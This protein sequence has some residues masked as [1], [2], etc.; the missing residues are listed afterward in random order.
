M[1]QKVN[2]VAMRLGITQE[3]KSKWF[4]NSR[5]Y[6]KYLNA[7]LRVRDFLLKKLKNASVSHIHI[8]RPARNAKVSI[9]SA[10][11]GVI[12]GKKGGEVE[13]LRDQVSK[14]MGVPVHL[15]IEEIRKPELNAKLVAEGIAQQL[16]RRI[17]FRRAM[18]RAVQSTLR[19]GALGIKVNVGGRLG[20]AEIARSE[21]YREGR[22]PLHTFRAD[23][24]YGT[25]RANTTY[26]V[27]GVKVWIFK[28]E[29]IDVK[30]E[31]PVEVQESAGEE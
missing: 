26:G 14:I 12:I 8:E 5:D 13:R 11:P 2:P 30:E 27:I 17:M 3:C 24:D 25:A 6:A 7:D 19:Q 16:E 9:Y 4:A 1:G 29:I 15:T 22:V 23:I 31:A 10:R 20:G 28:G 21:W 18:K